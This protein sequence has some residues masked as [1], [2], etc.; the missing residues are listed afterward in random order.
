M[1][2]IQKCGD[3]DQQK[4]PK[5]GGMEGNAKPYHTRHIHIHIV[6]L[7]LLLMTLN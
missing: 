3:F 5:P 7:L 2:G 1:D 6:L 4:G